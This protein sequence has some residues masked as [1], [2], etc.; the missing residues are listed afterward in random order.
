MKPLGKLAFAAITSLALAAT[1]TGNSWQPGTL[2]AGGAYYW[3]VA[4]KNSAGSASSGASVF[5]VA[6]APPTTTTS[7]PTLLS[8]AYGSTVTGQN[9]VFQWT[10]VAGATSYE[11][12]VGSAGAALSQVAVVSGTS[13]TVKGLKRRT[14]YA[15]KV[16]A[17]TPSGAFSS[18][19][20]GF[21]TN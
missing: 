2:A 6:T 14:V 7:G 21:Q 13:V 15:W 8:P 18:A 4:A 1:V 12:Y 17:R 11:V 3:Q 5:T 10:S 19:T 9:P 16:I 20:G